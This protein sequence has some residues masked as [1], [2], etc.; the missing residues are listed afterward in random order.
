MITSD[1]VLPLRHVLDQP[2]LEE[3][4]GPIAVIMTPT[5]ELAMQVPMC[6]YMYFIYITDFL[7][8][9]A[10]YLKSIIPHFI[11]HYS[12]IDRERL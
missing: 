12:T 3:G 2:P 4:D 7:S 6:K 1:L 8:P 9:L 5:R 11:F 10:Q